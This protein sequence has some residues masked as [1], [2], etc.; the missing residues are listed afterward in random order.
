MLFNG[1]AIFKNKFNRQSHFPT[2]L[3]LYYREP[4]LSPY[5]KGSFTEGKKL[6]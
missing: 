2:N 4:K 5:G 3:N 6:K 1:F